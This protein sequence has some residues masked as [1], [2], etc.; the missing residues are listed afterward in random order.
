MGR[1][2]YAAV[3]FN[4]DISA[5]DISAVTDMSMM[6]LSATLSTSNYDALLTGWSVQSVQ[7][8]VTFDGGNSMYSSAS[9]SARDTLTGAS[10][11]TIT[12]GGVAATL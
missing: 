6:F 11:W 12:D 7:S 10:N 4:Q 2:F 9:Q 8:N 1:M 3:A 5:W